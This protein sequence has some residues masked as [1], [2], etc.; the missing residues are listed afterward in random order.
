M[1][2]CRHARVY[3][4]WVELGGRWAVLLEQGRYAELLDLIERAS[5]GAGAEALLAAVR[6][7]IEQGYV[8]AAADLA[9]SAPPE[10]RAA[11]DAGAALRLWQGFL[12]LYDAGDRPFAELAAEFAG[13]CDGLG[14]RAGASPAVTALAVDLRSRAEEMRFLLSGLGPQ[15]RG[16]LVSCVAAV[17]DGY[18]GAGEPREAVAALR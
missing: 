11:G 7:R 10:V 5:D 3:P 8:R 13:L 16:P 9:R 14:T 4:A 6:C 1:R 17:A 12:G 15:H 18:R 2:S